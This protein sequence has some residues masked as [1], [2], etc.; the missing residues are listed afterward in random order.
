MVLFI[1]LHWLVISYFIQWYCFASYRNLV[2]STFKKKLSCE[3]TQKASSYT[4]LPFTV[5]DKKLLHIIPFVQGH[6]FGL[7]KFTEEWIFFGTFLHIGFMVK[8][9]L[10]SI[11]RWVVMFPLNKFGMRNDIE[12]RKTVILLKGR[13]KKRNAYF[14]NTL[15]STHNITIIEGSTNLIKG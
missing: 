11:K 13:Q 15:Y 6:K 10:V 12:T 7:I 5:L 9:L 2:S 8:D 4:F 3:N 1:G 14:I